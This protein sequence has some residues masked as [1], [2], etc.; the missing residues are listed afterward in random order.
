MNRRVVVTG[1]GAVTPLGCGVQTTWKRLL[2]G[3]SGISLVK[4]FDTTDIASKIAG[5]IPEEGEGAFIADHWVDP[6]E[7]RR[8]DRFIVLGI[9]A[10]TQALEDAG[11]KPISSTQKERTGVIIGSGIGGLPEISSTAVVLET[12]GPR[13]VS[14]FFVPASLINLVAGYVSVMFDLRG[15]NYAIVTACAAGS[16]SIGE[17]VRLIERG[18]AD[19]MV[20]GG[21]EGAVCPLGLSGFASMKALSTHYNDCPEKASRPWDVGRDG[22]V[23]GEGAGVVVLEDLEHALNRGAHIYGEIVGYGLSSDAYHVTAPSSTG[24][25]AV[26]AMLGALSSAGLRPEDI[27]YINAHGTSTPLGDRAELFAVRSIFKDIPVAMSSTKSST[28]H[29]LGA[30]GSVE[31]IFCLLALRDQKI[32]GTLN[33]TDCQEDVGNIDLVP[34]KSKDLECRYVLS[35]S[36]GFGGTNASLIF[37]TYNG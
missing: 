34:L 36:F 13:R 3:K 31:A 1:L 24:E 23:I 25:G 5:V 12:K 9:A 6:K 16:H 37:A 11:W 22:F 10:A 33:L 20:A 14:P 17:A 29:L 28:G 19:V 30:A 15:P 26:R 2:E 27:Q 4:S 8:M 7:Q 35:N 32:P 18:D 21:S